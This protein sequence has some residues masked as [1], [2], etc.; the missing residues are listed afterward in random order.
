MKFPLF[1]P[2]IALC[3]FVFFC[4]HSTGF[5]QGDA[6]SVVNLGNL[7]GG[8]SIANGINNSGQVFGYSFT[9]DFSIK[10]V[11]FS[12]TGSDH[13]D[14]GNLSG[15]SSSAAGM[16]NAGQIIGN[17]NTSEGVLR[18][19]L[20][21]GTGTGN[22]DLGTLGGDYSN[23]YGINN[24][25][26]IVGESSTVESGVHATLF[27]GTGSGN[28]DLGT[29]G[30]SESLAYGIN[31]SGQIVGYAFTSGNNQRATL[32]SG[33]GSGNTD[34][35]TLGG[36]D[37]VAFG[38]NNSGQ[39]VGYAFTSENAQ[40]ATLFSGTG[41]GNIDLGTLGGS[42]SYSV[43][44]NDSGQIV[45]NADLSGNTASHGYLYSNGEMRDV[46]NLAADSALAIG[47]TDIQIAQGKTINEW[48]QIAAFGSVSGG[49]NALLLNPTNPNTSTSNGALERNTKFVGGMSYSK[50][51]TTG[52]GGTSVSFLGGVAG[53]DGAGEFGANRDVDVSLTVGTGETYGKVVE[54]SG[55]EGDTFVLS[56]SYDEATLISLFGSEA[57]VELGWLNES[58]EWVKAVS[59]N[60]GGT[61]QF[62]EGAWD[63]TYGLGS[64]GVDVDTNSVWAVINHNSSFAII[65]AVPEPS[66]S[67]LSLAGGCV[68]F[69]RRKRNRFAGDGS[70]TL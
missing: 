3:G 11:L 65:N 68:L 30:G 17:A 55:T 70:V 2:K 63:E 5:A 41:T 53:S 12:G 60:T 24:S 1:F 44:I 49:V 69:L 18:A 22:I 36:S 19:T 4:S 20:F 54:I 14:L 38:I 32:F 57:N 37:S 61:E 67:I 15:S 52:D 50:F 58:G 31:D 62:I 21:S 47:V 35:G 26:Q 8:Y 66:L 13:T 28:I 25:G 46:N 59:G 40:R 51:T 42:S 10:A 7:G 23:A 6:Y 56:L 43:A 33:T 9:A 39:I 45:G 27:S 34:L 48:G 29:L 16:N 64:Y